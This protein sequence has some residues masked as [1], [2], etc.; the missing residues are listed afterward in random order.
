M[1]APTDSKAFGITV[2]AA[3]VGKAFVKVASSCR[4]INAEFKCGRR[5][6]RLTR[7]VRGAALERQENRHAVAGK[8]LGAE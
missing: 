7:V 5:V 3:I 1:V 8:C 2:P 6:D 4:R